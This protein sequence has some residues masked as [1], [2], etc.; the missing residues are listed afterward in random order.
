MIEDEDQWRPGSFT[1]NFGWGPS[2]D[3]LLRLHEMINVGFDGKAENVP[4]KQFRARVKKLGRPDYIA[5][6][7][8]LYNAIEKSEDV[9]VAD[10]LVFQATNF[11]HSHHFDKLGMFA[12]LLSLVGRWK[13]ASPNQ[14]RPAEWAR[15]YVQQI[16]GDEYSWDTSNVTA[17]DIEQYVERD[18]RFKAEGARKLATNLSY[19]VVQGRL[20]EFKTAKVQRWWVNA[21]FLALDRTLRERVALGQEVSES[22]LY[23]YLVT[24]GFNQLSGPRSIQKDLAVKHIIKLYWACGGLVRLSELRTRELEQL[25]LPHLAAYFSNNPEPIGAVYSGDPAIQ[26]TLPRFC[27]HLAKELANFEIMELDELESLDIDE[28]IKKNTRSAI[29]KLQKAG[30]KPTLTADQLFKITRDK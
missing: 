23:E 25:R 5:L 19:L 21:L 1:K 13:S 22:R 4:R 8:F 9:V 14:R 2:R 12:F 29:E 10:E 30:I 20:S 7:F 18:S 16:V 3:G 11:P 26:K 28:F 15:H 6:Q 27:A 24:S 17:T